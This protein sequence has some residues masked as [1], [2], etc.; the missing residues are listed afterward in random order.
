MAVGHSQGF[1]VL[2]PLLTTGW[3]VS[4]KVANRFSQLF[5]SLLLIISFS[6]FSVLILGCDVVTVDLVFVCVRSLFCLFFQNCHKDVAEC[7]CS[8]L[9]LFMKHNTIA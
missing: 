2:S 7:K 3:V 9:V 4:G 8:A 1:P 5:T 6:L